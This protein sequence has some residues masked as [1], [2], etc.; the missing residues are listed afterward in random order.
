LGNKWRPST[1]GDEVSLEYGKSLKGYREA[2]GPIQ[3]FG[4]NGAVG[5][6]NKALS[7]G[8]GVILGRKGAYRGVRYTES[9][10]YVIDTAYYVKSKAEHHMRWLY[11][12][13]IHHKLGEIDD[14]SPIP[15]TT[16]SAVYVTDVDI[17]PLP[18]QKAIAHILGTLDDKI[19]L[20]RWMNATLEGMAQALFKS[21]FVDFD[22]VIDN[23]LAAGNPIPDELAARAEVRR[24]ALANGTANR[25]AAKPFPAAFQ[26]TEAMG[27][28]PEGWEVT[29]VSKAISV[30]PS[31]KLKKG[32][33]A[34]FAD[35]KALPTS[36][37]AI[38]GVIEKAYSGGSKFQNGDV[39]LARI[40][41]C[42]ENG[43]TGVVDFLTDDNPVGFGSTEF[44]VLRGD[45]DLGTSFVACLARD[46]NFREHCEQSMIG[47]SGRQRVHNSCFDSY[48]L[49]LPKDQKVVSQ[50]NVLAVAAFAK[51]TRQSNE[52]KI[53][54]KLRDTL[55]PKLI[56][57]EIQTSQQF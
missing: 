5:W 48:H 49:A 21:W 35:M 31:T 11:Y 6:T 25:E 13:I 24:Q 43:K 53:L 7:D 3:V 52:N 42:L 17:P 44:I 41:P 33:F 34:P 28:I 45:C 4:S 27:W 18:E 14:G 54:A 29:A 9:P 20:N 46:S 57:G 16:R 1:W 32:D 19:E 8:P 30:N 39:L 12:A 51:A 56:S 23:A 26:Q 10:F 50:F 40:T 15:S 55:L 38:N 36:G 2:D 22:P 37:Y 47:S